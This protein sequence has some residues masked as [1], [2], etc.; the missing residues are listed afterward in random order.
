MFKFFQKSEENLEDFMRNNIHNL[1][2]YDA[3]KKLQLATISDREIIKYRE[4][5]NPESNL[6]N[7]YHNE[8][9]FHIESANKNI[10][11]TD[12]NLKFY[13]EDKI[14]QLA[15]ITD[16]EIIKNHGEIIKNFNPES[17]SEQKNNN[18]I[19]YQIESTNKNM[20]KDEKLSLKRKIKSIFVDWLQSS[21]SHGIPNIVRLDNNFLK[22][23][24]IICYLAS[25]SYCIYNIFQIIQS[26]LNL[27]VIINQHVIYDSP[28]EFPAVTVC[29]LNPFDRR[30]AKE[31]INMVLSNNNI[32]YVS[33][34]KKIDINPKIVNNLIKSSIQNDFNL[35][36][37]QK[38]KLGFELDYM[39]L[40]CFFNDKPCNVSDF[41]WRYDFDY[42]NC[43]TFNSGY[44]VNGNRVP[45]KTVSEAGFDMSLKLELF[46]GDD[47]SQSEFIL[48]SGA[49]VVIHN[50]SVTP[51]LRSDG[52]DIATGFQTNFGIKRSFFTKLDEP[53]S[54]CLKN[55]TSNSSFD[56]EF[57]RAMFNI[58]NMTT[59]RQKQCLRLCLQAFIKETCSCID[60][61]LP[62]IYIKN[63]PVCSTLDSLECISKSRIKYFGNVRDETC[64]ECPD[65]CN[66]VNYEIT[67]SNSRYPTLYYLNYLKY[68]TDILSRFPNP[69]N[70][71]DNQITKACVYLN[72]FY[73]DLDTIYTSE[74]PVITPESLFGN[75]GGNLGLFVG[76]SLLSLVEIIEL[77]LNIL[78]TVINSKF[79]NNI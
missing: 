19:T 58:L 79:K 46:L 35:T 9:T 54:K 6:Q 7:I 39:L 17:N 10:K 57:Y 55:L 4:N 51:I 72:V 69:N 61:S 3:Y 77:V 18:D 66:T 22:I 74:Q 31:Y 43:F 15:K 49:T 28:I 23:I 73:D 70:V 30:N 33:D 34:V 75:I 12:R 44:D 27:D 2:K 8:K 20:E 38:R 32:S 40:T 13:V 5:F 53:Y 60:G 21:T 56:S 65:E 36:M 16:G 63:I 41:I 29:N 47:A 14:D 48:N 37:Q 26:Y 11:I 42:T 1:K 45:I 50:Q 67:K 62:N 71:I 78:F 76:I 25:V 64:S 24:W 59:Y 68:H 52:N